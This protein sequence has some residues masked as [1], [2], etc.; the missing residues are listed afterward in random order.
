MLRMKVLVSGGSGF[1]G[2]S[3]IDFLKKKKVPYRV[4]DYRNPLK[5]IMDFTHAVHFGGL[6]PHSPRKRAPTSANYRKANVE[7]TRK[8][9]SVI[10]KNKKLKKLVNI[11]TAAELGPHSA[12]GKSKAQQTRI[13]GR[14]A[15]A[16]EVHT[17]NLRVFN[18]AA[19][20]PGA[21]MKKRGSLF[22]SLLRQ[23]S[24]RR[25]RTIKVA[26]RD[27]TRDFVDIDDVSKAV[28][29]AL[30]ARRGG[31][32]EVVN[33]CSGRATR[34][35]DVAALF[36]ARFD[37]PVTIMN[38]SKFPDHSVG[39]PRKAKRLLGWRAHI[40]LEKSVRKMVP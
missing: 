29:R 40:S 7:G 5:T 33:V 16:H 32:Y 19:V 37:K 24:K 15:R 4:Y 23:F 39:N 36:S 28:F 35:G 25:V 22:Q 6:T 2:S 20:S 27:S 30:R 1:L 11:G 18:V 14:F 26:H 12:Y 21:F 38:T 34:V 9:L 13:V 10:A 17:V 31:I 3:F 8:F